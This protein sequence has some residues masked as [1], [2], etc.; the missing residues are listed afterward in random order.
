MSEGNEERRA[1]IESSEKLMSEESTLYR[2]F[3]M[4]L[5]Y[6]AQDRID[7]AAAVKC[8]TRHMKEPRSAH[9]QKLKRLGP[10]LGKNKRCVLTYA[11]QTS[12]ATLQVFCGL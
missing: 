1:Q 4:K 3:V 9:M 7:I 5:A 12:D 10:Y 2:S 6:V 8:V 11:R